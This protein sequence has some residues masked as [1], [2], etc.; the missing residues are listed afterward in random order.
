MTKV[1]AAQ[2]NSDLANRRGRRPRRPLA[3]TIVIAP[4][5]CGVLSAKHEEVLLGCIPDAHIVGSRRVAPDDTNF[6]QPDKSE[7]GSGF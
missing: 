4:V 1:S 7:F 5:A 3:G 6:K 2:I